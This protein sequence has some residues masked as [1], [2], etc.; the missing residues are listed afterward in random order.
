MADAMTLNEAAA[1]LGVS[2]TTLRCQAGAGRIRAQKIG[3]LWTVTPA[4][5]ERYRRESLGKPGRR[6]KR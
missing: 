1:A 6:R 5:V 3:P 2:P 4:E